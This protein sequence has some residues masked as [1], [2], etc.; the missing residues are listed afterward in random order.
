[1][2]YHKSE[3][4]EMIIGRGLLGKALCGVDDEKYLFYV[5]G[6]ANSMAELI[7]ENNFEINEIIQL[8]K[9]NQDKVFIYLST[10]QVNAKH[11][12]HRPYVLH[13]LKV[14]KLIQENFKNYLI[15]RTSNLV[16]YNPWNEHTLF[17]FL[18]RAIISGSLVHINPVA[19]RNILDVSDFAILLQSYL[20]HY[21]VNR[22]IEI[23]NPV[24][25]NMKEV[26]V[27]FEDF[28]QKKFNISWEAENMDIALFEFNT[29]LSMAL[30][31]G[32]NLSTRNYIQKVL[33]KYYHTNS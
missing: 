32:C 7:P 24:S 2:V 20:Q 33:S 13:K 10:S 25:F 3:I 19:I 12:R 8:A 29:D 26:V 28:F 17:N 22:V 1:M 15:I 9:L 18:Y 23:V 4:R 21:E 16:G 27:I 30:F 11:N 14:E 5:N 31:A 6:L